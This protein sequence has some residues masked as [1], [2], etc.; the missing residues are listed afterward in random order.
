MGQ[1]RGFQIASGAIASRHLENDIAI[2]GLFSVESGVSL[3]GT[4]SVRSGAQFAEWVNITGNAVV[5]GSF[6]VSGASALESSLIVS[7][8]S[9]LNTLVV[10]G[11]SAGIS[12][13]LTVANASYFQNNV[14]ISG[15]SLLNSVNITGAGVSTMISGSIQVSGASSE[16]A[17]AVVTG[18]LGVSGA[19]TLNT[20]EVTGASAVISGALGVSGASSLNTLVV[21]GASAVISGTLGVTGAS[22]LNTLNVTG[23]SADF[24]G[25]ATIIGALGV[26]G[27]S[28][29]NSVVV[30]GASATISGALGVSGASSLAITT[31]TGALSVTAA[32]SFSSTVTLAADPVSA[33]QAATKQYVDHVAQGLTVKEMVWAASA[34]A[35]PAYGV[36]KVA[37]ALATDPEVTQLTAS[38]DGALSLDG[39]AVQD[40]DR[41]LIKNEADAEYNGIYVVVDKGSVSSPW[42]IKRA[43]DANRVSELP[44]GTYCFVRNGTLQPNTSWVLLSSISNLA[45]DGAGDDLTFGQFSGA[46][47]LQAGIN[48]SV[49]GNTVKLGF[50]GDTNVSRLNKEVQLVSGAGLIINTGSEVRFKGTAA[51]PSVLAIETGALI[52]FFTDESTYAQANSADLAKLVDSSVISGADGLHSHALGQL[53]IREPLAK[54]TIANASNDTITLAEGYDYTAPNFDVPAAGE[55]GASSIEVYLNGQLIEQGTSGEIMPKF[56]FDRNNRVVTVYGSVDGDHIYVRYFAKSLSV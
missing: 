56:D 23:A 1:F 3:S 34:A 10:T 16:L 51:S 38:G 9:T 4:L 46:G 14:N 15:A 17:A 19:S 27:A 25:S 13:I 21:S 11:A 52:R 29:L 42:I 50:D 24:S 18:A 8:A 26:S 55:A 28:T 53:G 31:I 7:G 2:R 47:T 54:A 22:T 20:L 6:T 37:A 41:V 40:G 44:R 49:D 43:E 39:Y 48:M 5:S 12:G 33:L 32:A 35:L 36:D 30:T 45:I